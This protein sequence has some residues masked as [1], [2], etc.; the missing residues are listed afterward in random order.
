MPTFWVSAHGGLL[1]GSL[2]KTFFLLEIQNNRRRC[3]LRASRI[4]T[5]SGGG[6]LSCCLAR[7]RQHL[8]CPTLRHPLTAGSGSAPGLVISP[9]SLT[10]IL[11]ALLPAM[12]SMIHEKAVSEHPR[13]R[14]ALTGANRRTRC[15]CNPARRLPACP[16][17][18]RPVSPSAELPTCEPAQVREAMFANRRRR[19]HWPIT[20]YC[21][22]EIGNGPPLKRYP[23]V[24]FSPL[25]MDPPC[26]KW[27]PAPPPGPFFAVE[28]GPPVNFSPLK[29]DPR[30]IFTR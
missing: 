2:L 22:C 5:N 20:C 23:P 17:A 13:R 9:P 14:V 8:P 28:N 12:V 4:E 30:S 21:R 10:E 29:M 3:P 16:P 27:T 25:K 7:I 26:V 11:S 6:P 1:I 19:R 24:H 18:C 15:V